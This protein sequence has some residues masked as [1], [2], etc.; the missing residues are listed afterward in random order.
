MNPLE[1][2]LRRLEPR[3]LPDDF[4]EVVRSGGERGRGNRPGLKEMATLAAG[5]AA[6]A[7]AIVVLVLVK[8]KPA[9][10][11]QAA[12]RPATSQEPDPV[13]SLIRKLRSSRA[14]EKEEAA[15]RIKDQFPEAR[16]E[17]ERAIQDPESRVAGEAQAILVEMVRYESM[18]RDEATHLLFH[19]ATE[20]GAR[21]TT[22]RRSTAR[23]SN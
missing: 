12:L 15:R 2:R 16:P 7:F 1:E 8:T 20:L 5:L 19:A 18:V 11:Q 23:I 21:A 6:A 17:V 13:S 10:P 14:D 22:P 9:A 3:P 4:W